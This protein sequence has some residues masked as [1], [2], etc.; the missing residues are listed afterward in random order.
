[1]S[2]DPADAARARKRPDHICEIAEILSAALMR[3]QARK[4]SQKLRIDRESSLH[5]SA[6][7][8]GHPDLVMR[9]KS[10]EG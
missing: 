7:K 5:I 8:S 3:L 2:K 4:S 6:A 10:D 1:M 9:K